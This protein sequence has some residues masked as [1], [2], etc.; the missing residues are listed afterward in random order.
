M[1]NVE[2][3]SKKLGS[4]PFVTPPPPTSQPSGFIL[5][6]LSR[7]TCKIYIMI[8]YVMVDALQRWGH[9]TRGGGGG[10]GGTNGKGPKTPI[11]DSY[12]NCLPFDFK[13][14]SG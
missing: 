8:Y 1:I 13:K 3:S 14:L 12:I 11:G 4:F 10:G 6:A 2:S 7:R 5:L 9:N